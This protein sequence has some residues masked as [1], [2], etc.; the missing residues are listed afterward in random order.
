MARSLTTASAIA[1]LQRMPDRSMRSL[2]RFLQAPST[3]RWQCAGLRRGIG[4][5]IRVAKTHSP[6][7]SAIRKRRGRCKPLERRFRAAKAAPVPPE[8]GGRQ[9]TPRT[10][11]D[12][13]LPDIAEGSMWHTNVIVRNL[14]HDWVAMSVWAARLW[15]VERWGS[16]PL[17]TAS[18][19]PGKRRRYPMLHP[20]RLPEPGNRGDLGLRL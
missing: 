9:W 13:L 12:M 1:S 19:C 17:V 11:F 2:M 18:T 5:S 7:A 4:R 3:G 10:S 15:A 8:G 20:P 6:L 14:A 16:G